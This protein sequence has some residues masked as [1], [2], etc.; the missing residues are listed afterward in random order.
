MVAAITNAATIESFPRLVISVLTCEP[1]P[2]IYEQYGHTAIR[3]KEIV[4]DTLSQYEYETEVGRKLIDEVFNYGCFDF[5]APNFILRFALG[6]TDYMVVSYPYG[7]FCR[8]YIQQN[9]RVCEQTLNLTDEE[10]AILAKNLFENA[11]P[12]NREYRYNFLYNNCTTKCR[13]MIEGAINLEI[14]YP[15]DIKKTTFREMMHQYNQWDTKSKLAIDLLL[16]DAVDKPISIRDKM[17]APEYFMKSINDATLKD[18]RKLVI[19]NEWVVNPS[20]PYKYDK[21]KSAI[22][23]VLVAVAI[24][25]SLIRLMIKKAR[26]YDIAIITITGSIGIFVTFMY[27]LSYHPAVDSNWLV[28]LF[29]PLWFVLFLKKVQFHRVFA[30]ILA[31]MQGILIVVG[32]FEIQEIPTIYLIISMITAYSGICFTKIR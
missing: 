14:D 3:V 9:R 7:L 8:E 30:I 12:K 32:I 28:L 17:F 23:Y 27:F 20:V 2:V 11:L 1:G 6:K 22:E 25:L 15:K 21:E 4:P 5:T 31:F 10:A 18:G 26:I 16:G 19:K 13:D 24:L 29:N